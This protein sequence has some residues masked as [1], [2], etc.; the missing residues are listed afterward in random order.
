MAFKMNGFSAFTKK[1][2]KVIRKKSDVENV[3]L[4]EGEDPDTNIYKGDVY[5]EK[6]GD[7]EDRIEFIEQ[8]IE[9]RQDG[10][11]KP[12]QRSALATLDQKLRELRKSKKA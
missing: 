4:L 12:E 10:K 1:E 11:M 6:I 3:P 2:E 9:L 8:D 5:S 7:V